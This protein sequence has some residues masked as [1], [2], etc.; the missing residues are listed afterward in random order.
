MCPVN[1]C[2]LKDDSLGDPVKQAD[3][4]AALKAKFL[5]VFEG[6]GKLKGYQLKVHMDRNVRPVA[7]PLRQIPFSKRAKVNEKL[8]ELL[9]LDVIEKAEGQTSLVNPLVVVEKPSGDIRI[10]LDMRQAN[11]A[12]VREKQAVPTVEETLQ[13]VS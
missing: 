5:K 9:H 4:K 12:I 11:E 10:C 13:E 8:N 3:K 2:E 7:H 1:N 6:L